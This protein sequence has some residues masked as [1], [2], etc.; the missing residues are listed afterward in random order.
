MTTRYV[1]PGGL[2]TNDGLSWATRYLTLGKAESVVAAGDTVIVGPGVYRELLTLSA[3]GTSGNPIIYVGDPSGSRTDGIGGSCRLTGAATATEIY[4]NN[5]N[6]ITT[7]GVARNFRTFRGM[8]FDWSNGTAFA[9]AASSNWIIEDCYF[10]GSPHNA[11]APGYNINSSGV[12][13]NFTIRRCL[14]FGGGWFIT[15]SAQVNDA[16]L[17]FE[18]NIVVGGNYGVSD[19]RIGGLIVRNNLFMGV[20]NGVANTLGLQAAQRIQAYN[21]QFVGCGTVFTAANVNTIVENYNG[22]IAC[23]TFRTNV[24]VGGNSGDQGVIGPPVFVPPMLIAGHALPFQPFA[25]SEFSSE[26]M[27]ADSPNTPPTDDFF[28]V[29]RPAVNGKRSWGPIQYSDVSRST[30]QTHTGASSLR[31]ADFGRHQMIVPLTTIATTISVWVFREAGYTGTAP[32]LTVKQVG[33]ADLVATDTGPAGQW[34]QLTLTFTP[35]A[36]PAPAWATVELTSN[37]TATAGSYA[38]YFDDL[39]VA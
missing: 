21:N 16:N 5:N 12:V 31:I 27:A 15:H 13:T 11:G 30:V 14:F 22:F 23:M 3:S 19:E 8:H 6:V 1:G 38:A 29:P 26:R 36:A 28:G 20:A 4:S 35:A 32:Q 9:L 25:L 18:N 37:N 17:L 7:S 24:N 39:S 34:N 2:D 33:Q 10:S